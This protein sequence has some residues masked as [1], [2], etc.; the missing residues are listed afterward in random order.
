VTVGIEF[1]HVHPKGVLRYTIINTRLSRC[2][3]TLTA[4]KEAGRKIIVT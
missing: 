3:S 1:G 4:T 2:K